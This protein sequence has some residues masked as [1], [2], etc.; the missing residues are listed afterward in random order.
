MIIFLIFTGLSLF[1]SLFVVSACMLSSRI[2]QRQ[3][4]VEVYDHRP[5]SSI[6]ALPRSST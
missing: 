6:P 1:I 2:S 5:A 4:L 3:Q